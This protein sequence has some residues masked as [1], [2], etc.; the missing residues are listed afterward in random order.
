MSEESKKRDETAAVFFNRGRRYAVEV[1]R[2]N[3]QL[4]SKIRRL[5]Q[6][7][8]KTGDAGSRRRSPGENADEQ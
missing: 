7:L 2:D 6:A 4:R 8:R 5:E 1:V 3:E